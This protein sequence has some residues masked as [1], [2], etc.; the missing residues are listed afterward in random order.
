VPRGSVTRQKLFSASRVLRLERDGAAGAAE[1]GRRFGRIARESEKVPRARAKPRQPFTRLG[2]VG[3]GS[4]VTTRDHNLGCGRGPTPVDV[5]P[6][7][8]PAERRGIRGTPTE[9]RLEETTLQ[10]DPAVRRSGLLRREAKALASRGNVDAT[11]A[12]TWG[13]RL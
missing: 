11:C 3:L 2:G 8:E 5:A 13:D 1:S 12:E 10:R 6:P 7:G 9:R 4:R